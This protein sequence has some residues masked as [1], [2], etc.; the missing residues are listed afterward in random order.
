[1][2]NNANLQEYGIAPLPEI[3][4]SGFIPE[5]VPLGDLQRASENDP[6][7][8]IK[9][10]FLCRGGGLL[11]V[12][13]TGI[14]KSSLSMQL[15]L[16]W[17]IG[18]PCFGLTPARPLKSLIVQAENDDGD[19]A[20]M[21]DGVLN[22]L[23]FDDLERAKAL[24]N[25]LTCRVDDVCGMDFFSKIV[26]PLLE[27]HHPDL[28]N[29]DPL[30]AYLGGDVSRQEVVSPWLRNGLNP[31]LTKHNCAC[32]L[33]HHTNKPKSGTEKPDWQAGDFAYLGSGSAELANWSRA[34][35]AMRSIGS[36]EVFE[37]ILAKRGG[38]AGWK[39]PEGTKR[40]SS[41]LAHSKVPGEICWQEVDA[42]SVDVGQK[43]RPVIH[44]ADD[45][46]DLLESELT[47]KEWESLASEECGISKRSFFRLKKTAMDNKLVFK[48]L[49]GKWAK[50]P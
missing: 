46:A 44:S 48:T 15:M 39:T 47:S 24:A 6:G 32:V 12:G 27:Q 36:N 2:M 29:P 35:A 16:S 49:S 17:A 3:E 18:R 23:G 7:E 13:P 33:V 1:M 20:E 8:L 45:I 41:F 37:F 11:L 10:R 26:S 28:L 9:H 5:A 38:R 34:V 21:R 30:L 40:Y 14:G 50:Q 25:V 31:L 19:L 42:D 43:G 22:G 4:E